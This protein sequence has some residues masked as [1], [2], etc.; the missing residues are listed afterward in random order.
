[1][2]INFPYSFFFIIQCILEYM[3]VFYFESRNSSNDFVLN[4]KVLIKCYISAISL[5]DLMS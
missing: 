5:V 1:M 2:A 4:E 3:F